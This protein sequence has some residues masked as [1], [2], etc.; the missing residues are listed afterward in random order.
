MIVSQVR[1][2]PISQTA[3]MPHLDRAVV[4]GHG[5]L[6]HD[7]LAF[8]LWT[9]R[10]C[11][12]GPM[13][14]MGASTLNQNQVP[15]MHPSINAYVTREA[16]VPSSEKRLTYP[17][18]YSQVSNALEPHH[19]QLL[20]VLVLEH[21]AGIGL[22]CVPCRAEDEEG[23]GLA[24]HERIRPV[25]TRLRGVKMGAEK[26]EG[27]RSTCLFLATLPQSRGALSA[28]KHYTETRA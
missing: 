19:H 18:L 11:K 10:A 17:L 24:E 23:E 3:A 26:T 28:T 9:T 20:A 5:L 12:G 8:K 22:G 13:Q 6:V 14:A 2:K 7:L 1:G 15:Y 25:V 16:T 27:T 4:L 21:V